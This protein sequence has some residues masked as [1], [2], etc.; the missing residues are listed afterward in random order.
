MPLP[1]SVVGSLIIN[2]LLGFSAM[3]LLTA[4]LRH[5]ASEIGKLL[6][7]YNHQCPA[8]GFA[9]V[10]IRTTVL[11]RLFT[12]EIGAERPE[13]EKREEGLDEAKGLQTTVAVES[14]LT[15]Q[16]SASPGT[17]QTEPEAEAG[18]AITGEIGAKCS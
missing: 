13:P 16:K 15:A 11:F 17:T 6:E 8:L 14:V 7:A 2:L 12:L 5:V 10:R 4:M 9:P 18:D 3:V 1:Y